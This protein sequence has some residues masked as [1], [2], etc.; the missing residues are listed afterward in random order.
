LG[1]RLIGLFVKI[2]SNRTSYERGQLLESA[3]PADPI[4][5]LRAWLDDAFADAATIDANAMCLA[6][7]DGRGQ[8]SAR[9]VLLRG[10]DSRGLQFFTSYLSRKG[11][12]IAA[13]PLVAATFFWPSLQRQVRVEGR[14]T[15]LGDDES[16]AY[17]AS[18]PA[19]HRLSAWASE[20]SRPVEGREVLEERMEHFAARF[21]GEEIPRPHSWGGYM[22]SAQRFEFW[23]GRKNRLHD[24]LEYRRTGASWTIV[25]LQP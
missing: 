24:R 5:Q 3:M 6:S 13:N 8:P 10:L 19:E 15:P 18:R 23:Q 25:R 7:V 21:E 14:A 1:R 22:I 16:D 17:F 9:V 12:E 4:E 20:Q 2:A 11:E